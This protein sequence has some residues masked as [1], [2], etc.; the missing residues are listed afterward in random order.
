M[1]VPDKVCRVALH[2]KLP[3][4]PW[5][6][7]EAV[8]T[9]HVQASSGPAGTA[10]DPQYVADQV[11]GALQSHWTAINAVYP[12]NVE[13]TMVKA[14]LLDTAAKTTAEGQHTWSAGYMTGSGTG[15]MLPPEVAMCLSQYAYT[16][17]GFAPRK[18][19]RR[20]RMFLGPISKGFCNSDG[21][22][23]TTDAGTLLTGWQTIMNQIYTLHPSAASPDTLDVVILSKTTDATYA[24]QNLAIDDHFDSMRS[25]QHQSPTTRQVAALTGW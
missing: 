24:V 21:K 19:A 20:G 10:P 15:G 9:F 25:R 6:S 5:P 22:V 18:G 13:L 2:F 1:P 8:N 23:D 3:D 12:T 16:P 11:A 7:E 4:T 17:G 14:Y